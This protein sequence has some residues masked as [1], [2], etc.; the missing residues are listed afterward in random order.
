MNTATRYDL[1]NNLCKDLSGTYVEIGTC[2]GGF[3]KWLVNFTPLTKLVC[4]DPYRVFS[5]L[6]YND[7]LNVSTQEY[8]D[9][10]FTKVASDLDD[11]SEGKATIMRLTSSEAAKEFPNE[12]LSF[13]YI[14]GN[15]CYKYAKQDILDWIGKVAPG[16]ILAGDDVET[17]DEPHDK[18]G[19]LL[20]VH[21][22]DPSGNTFGLYGVHKALIDIKA[23]FPWFD[24]T[25]SGSQFWWRKPA[26]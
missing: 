11:I 25:I 26:A 19:D 17:M 21:A 16:G 10:K 9:I 1:Y 5:M 14:D 23:E 12:S 6:E 13:V 15:H 7:A 24:Y 4:V 18:N 2:W 22:G 8:L 3:A 20:I